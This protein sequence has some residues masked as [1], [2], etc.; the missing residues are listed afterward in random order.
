MS[1]TVLHS[2]YSFSPGAGAN[3]KNSFWPKSCVFISTGCVDFQTDTRGTNN[4][5]QCH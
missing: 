4:R 1:V 5:G 3:I 2:Q